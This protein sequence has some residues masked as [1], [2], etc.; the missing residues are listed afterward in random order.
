M[1]LVP[2]FRLPTLIHTR[3]ANAKYLNEISNKHPMWI[4]TV[5]AKRWDLKTG[6]MVRVTTEIGYFV[7]RVWVTEAVRPGVVALSHHM[8]RWRTTDDAGSRWVS[9]K[10]DINQL[11]DGRWRLR[12]KEMVRPFASGDPDSMRIT[13]EDPGVHQNLAFAVHPDPWSGMHCW[14]QKVTIERAH[15][16]DKYGDVVVDTNRSREV[17]REWLGK[18]RP[19]PNA[20]GQRRPEFM[21]RP[22]TPQR[23]AYYVGDQE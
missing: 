10:V 22:M 19:G 4:N 7:V 20:Q 3:S 12:Y 1:L 14:H 11:G 18:T 9:G 21:M 2:T 16:E 23:R 17:Y 13:W 6:D 5:D 15:E 8:G